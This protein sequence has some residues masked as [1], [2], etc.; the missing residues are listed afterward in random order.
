MPQKRKQQTKSKANGSYRLLETR[1]NGDNTA[2]IWIYGIITDECW[3]ENDVTSNDVIR[4]LNALPAGTDRIVVHINSNG[5]DVFEG[6]A[7]YQTLLAHPAHIEVVG[8]GIVASIASVIA[9]AGDHFAMTEG[10]L[11]MIHNPL[12][13]LF[14]GFNK[15]DMAKM[16]EDLD[17]VRDICLKAYAAKTGLPDDGIIAL[18]DGSDGQ[19][20]YLTPQEALEMG[21]CDSIIPAKQK[22]VAM[23]Q[24]DSF[25]CRGKT[26]P[27]NIRKPPQS[28]NG[29]NTM[30]RKSRP[31]AELLTC[32]CPYCQTQCTLNTETNVVTMDAYEYATVA[33]PDNS[34]PD[35]EARASRKFRNEKYKIPCPNPECKKEFDYDTAPGGEATP[36]EESGGAYPETYP[37]PQAKAKVNRA[38]PKSKRKQQSAARARR[39]R[40]EVYPVH[41]T[42][43]ECENEFDIDV[44]GYIEEAIVTCPN[45]EAELDIDTSNVDEGYIE[46]EGEYAEVEPAENE[47]VVTARRQGA[48]N[49]RNRLMTLDARAKAFPQFADAIEQFK[50]NGSSIECVNNWIFQALEAGNQ[51]STPYLANAKKDAAI[52]SRIGNPVRV[53]SQEHKSINAFNSIAQRR[54]TLK[55]G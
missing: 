33:V 27:L 40:M 44:D 15:H 35:Y 53:D 37:I 23:I 50:R 38:R 4:A 49:E 26:I 5:G 22:M 10:S 36:L 11:L 28:M 8:E 30:P 9:M 19:G 6:S 21:F 25:R 54:G 2:D 55:N 43:T 13:I 45:C 47:E 46:I 24:P 1:V 32:T 39:A 7:I 41:I 14:G 18:L 20:T 31:R 51:T 42:C 12:V 3:S 17:K 52:L 48:A 34:N 16:S 29:G